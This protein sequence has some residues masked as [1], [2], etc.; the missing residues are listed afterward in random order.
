MS[1]SFN[2]EFS[3]ILC[4]RLCHDL[5]SPIGAINSGIELLEET[6]KPENREI[7]DLIAQSATVA[8]KRLVLFRFAFGYGAHV[9]CLNELQDIVEKSMDTKF[10]VH[11]NFPSHLLA[12]HNDLK[13]WA[14]ILMNTLII[15]SEAAPYGGHIK[16]SL[17]PGD[18]IRFEAS[19]EAQTLTL[20]EGII[21]VLENR[22][23]S[24]AL[25]SRNIQ[26]TLILLLVKKVNYKIFKNT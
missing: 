12:G 20:L 8:A 17:I 10:K 5:V 26:A 16:V 25:T 13:T 19:L 4:S 9:S 7:I 21:E 15:L 1:N 18:S 6:C 23:P 24:S 14:Q 11:W 22:L 2:L 3:Q